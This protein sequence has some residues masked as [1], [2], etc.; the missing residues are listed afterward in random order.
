MTV[1]VLFNLLGGGVLLAPLCLFIVIG[2]MM[3]AGMPLAEWA[4]TRITQA[5]VF[6][7][8]LCSVA[9]LVLMLATGRR[10]V[11]VD[12]GDLV[13][14]PQEH[15]H[16]QLR[17]MFD[18]LSVPFVV[19]TYVLVGTIGAFASRYLHRES[20]FGRF[21]LLYAMFLLGMIVATASGTIETLFFGWELVGLSSALLVAFFH[22]RSA[23]VINGQR[24]W[25]IYRVADAAF[26]IAAVMLHHT[27]GTGSFSNLAGSGPWP[28]G[29]TVLN[30]RDSLLIGSLLL[31]AAAGKSGLVPFSGWLPRAMEGP[32]P[33][34]AVFY[35][36][37]SVH[38]GAFLLLRMS[39]LLD[40]SMILSGMVVAL[41]L[42]TATLASLAARVQ[43]DVKSNLAFASLTQV[44]I[45]TAEIG[46]G[47]R[48]IPLIHIIG[49]A[50]LR[51]L[52]LL[53]APNVLQDY[54]SI[55]NAIGT[56]L[57]Q[58]EEILLRRLPKHAAIRIYRLA[59]ER[60]Y[61]DDLIDRY[62]VR[63]FLGLFGWF[64]KLERTTIGSLDDRPPQDRA[65]TPRTEERT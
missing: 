47:L 25:S 63:P 28:A 26:L 61:L 10:E 5:A 37:L 23:P 53:R 51:T 2:F 15:F 41:G 56:R 40:Q 21:F 48:Y 55:E 27:L 46:L 31:L 4:I 64:E 42:A 39:P 22:E 52:Q 44:G 34:S 35:G 38:L 54:Q 16:F 18:R 49:H 24:I 13:T 43:F 65:T 9:I 58:Q 12:F 8:L 36:A 20:G 1:G 57:P 50:C 14:I 11:L 45:I 60:G 59:F 6:C 30:P 29:T 32:T 19:L 7:G 3:L 62:V 17:F 33:S